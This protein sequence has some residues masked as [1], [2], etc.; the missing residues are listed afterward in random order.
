MLSNKAMQHG[1][2]CQ[3]HIFRQLEVSTLTASL[4]FVAPQ[5]SHTSDWRNQHYTEVLH[6]SHAQ[7]YTYHV[8]L[9]PL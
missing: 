9:K 2:A 6:C 4:E 8:N 3:S 5:I 1:V 7:N